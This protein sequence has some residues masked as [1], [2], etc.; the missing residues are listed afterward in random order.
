MPANADRALKYLTVNRYG[1]AVGPD[2]PFDLWKR[3]QPGRQLRPKNPCP[4]IV[5]GF[6]VKMLGQHV[7]NHGPVLVSFGNT[8][9]IDDT[10][11]T[12]HKLR[13]F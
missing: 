11:N 2:Y 5:R 9:R 13:A 7:V 1:P 10:L 4:S 12:L 6:L 8:I 3:Q